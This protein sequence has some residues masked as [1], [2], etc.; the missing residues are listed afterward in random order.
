MINYIEKTAKKFAKAFRG[1]LTFSNLKNY[2]EKTLHYT[3]LFFDSD[4]GKKELDRLGLVIPE[5]ENSIVVNSHGSKIVFIRST[6]AEDDKIQSLLHEAGHISLGHMEVSNL[7]LDSRKSERDAEKFSYAVLAELKKDR[8]MYFLKLIC[9]TLTVLL[10][11]QVLPGIIKSGNDN[12]GTEHARPASVTI[13]DTEHNP[14]A[15]TN[16]IDVSETE[17]EKLQNTYYV[18]AYGEKYHNPDCRYVKGKEN[19]EQLTLEEAKQ[20]YDSCSVCRP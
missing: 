14:G 6:L 12:S 19:L 15:L 4:I 18:T 2:I 3:V 17:D 8:V 9:I 20:K 13:Q 10:F 5:T 16:N 1:E 7:E 11:L